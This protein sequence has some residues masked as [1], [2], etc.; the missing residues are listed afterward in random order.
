V[1]GFP[2]GKQVASN[3]GLIPHEQSSKGSSRPDGGI[4]NQASWLMR[5]LLVEAANITVR[6]DQGFERSTRTAVIRS[7]SQVAKVAAAR[8]DGNSDLLDPRQ[9]KAAYACSLIESSLLVFNPSVRGGALFSLGHLQF[10][11]RTTNI[12]RRHLRPY[13][14]PDQ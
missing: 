10:R 14:G 7:T 8:E 2:R 9:S 13:G 6:F 12:E 5:I 11:G 3:R 4:S 1:K